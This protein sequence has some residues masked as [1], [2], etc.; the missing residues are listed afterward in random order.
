MEQTLAPSSR[1]SPRIRASL[2]SIPRG[3]LKCDGFGLLSK[4][5]VSYS[6]I[7]SGFQLHVSL[8]LCPIHSTRPR[9][10][11]DTLYSSCR[12]RPRAKHYAYPPVAYCVIQIAAFM[13]VVYA[14]I[15]QGSCNFFPRGEVSRQS[16]W[17]AS[18]DEEKN[19]TN[20]H[21]LRNTSSSM[22]L[23]ITSFPRM[24]EY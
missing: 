7:D 21:E 18:Y 23:T 24:C 8:C 19:R 14:V 9:S 5:I 12:Y 16:S 17:L 10:H 13:D 3:A 1:A 15:V 6:S 4:M 11:Q 22:S 20:C 2:R